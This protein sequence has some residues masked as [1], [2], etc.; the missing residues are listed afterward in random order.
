MD[1][2]PLIA[3]P[4]AHAGLSTPMLMI[5]VMVA[6]IPATVFGLGLYGWPA[7]FLFVVTVASAVACEVACLRLAGKPLATLGDG[8]AVL[9]GWILA[10]TLPATVVSLLVAIRHNQPG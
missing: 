6:L 1:N 5:W 9:S 2:R 7:I 10:L 8:S 3:G 4:F